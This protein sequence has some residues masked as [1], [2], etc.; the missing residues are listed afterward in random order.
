MRWTRRATLKLA[1]AMAGAAA[2]GGRMVMRPVGTAAREPAAMQ[3]A[4]PY[5]AGHRIVSFYGTPL[6]SGLGALGEGTTGSMLARLRAQAAAYAELDPALP[7]TPALHL[8]YT[9]AQSGPTAAGD[10]LSHAPDEMVDDLVAVARENGM[11]LFLDNQMGTSTIALE[12]AL[13]ARWLA[14]PHVHLALDPEYAWGHPS[15]VPG[16]GTDGDIGYLTAAQ[17]NEAQATLQAIARENGLPSKILIVHQFRHGMLPDKAAIGAYDGVELSILMDGFGPPATKLATY[18]AV[19]TQDGV[20][21]PGFKLFY[22]Y[23]VPLM[24][25]AQVV[26]LEPAPVVVMYQ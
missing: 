10:Y 4:A 19:I 2:L 7:V 22:E 16:G 13:M 12:M 26:A 8:I 9:V 11:L 3:P 14:E 5:L 1:T 20:L 23:D 24:T 6:A 15:L 18:D 21:Y 17:V 25:P